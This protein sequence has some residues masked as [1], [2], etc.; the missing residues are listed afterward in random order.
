MPVPLIPQTPAIPVR[1][2]SSAASLWSLEIP[3]TERS[4]LVGSSTFKIMA[5]HGWYFPV[6]LLALL[7]HLE[8]HI[9]KSPP[10]LTGSWEFITT[11]SYEWSLIRG[12]RP[13]RWTIWVSDDQLL[14]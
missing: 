14:H 2:Q 4:A 6:S 7:P 5:H 12:N 1:T 11:M 8:F 10:T 13:Y 3:L 9:T